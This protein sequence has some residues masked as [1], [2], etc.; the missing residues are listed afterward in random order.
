MEEKK[1][2]L[3]LDDIKMFI[4][5]AA[6]TVCGDYNLNDEDST[7]LVSVAADICKKIHSHLTGECEF[8]KE[9]IAFYKLA[10]EVTNRV[11]GL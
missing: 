8:T 3:S 9:Q 6:S 2:E 7:V 11:S 4:G 5:L 10:M 1:Y